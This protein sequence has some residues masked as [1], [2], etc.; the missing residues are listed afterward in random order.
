MPSNIENENI[1]AIKL[2]T[3]DMTKG[4]IGHQEVYPNT[5]EIQS[6]AWTS[7]STMSNS[8]GD[9]VLRVTG[10]ESAS[11]DLAITGYSGG[12]NPTGSYVISASPYDHSATIPAN[13]SC[14]APA[15]TI[16]STLTPT[17]STTLQGGGST[18]TSSFTQSAGPSIN[19]ANSTLSFGTIVVNPEYTTVVNG[20]TVW[21]S[22]TTLNITLAANGNGTSIRFAFSGLQSYSY[23]NGYSPLTALFPTSPIYGDDIFYT[24]SGTYNT[25]YQCVLSGSS[26]KVLS[27]IQFRARMLSNGCNYPASGQTSVYVYSNT[28][29]P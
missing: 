11:Y 7:T 6:A 12:T 20:N 27:A 18:F 28:Q 8:G 10:E 13:T 2:G 29:Y 17:G 4:Y 21:T 3:V 5:R 26:S 14:G 23:P 22:G 24:G 1:S 9:R 16:L 15:R 25:T 19:V